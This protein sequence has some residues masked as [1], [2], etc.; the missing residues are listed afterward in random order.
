M[1]I[2]KTIEENTELENVGMFHY[3]HETDYGK[4]TDTLIVAGFMKKDKFKL[5]GFAES[6][7]A[8][9]LETVKTFSQAGECEAVVFA[10]RSGFNIGIA[11]FTQVQNFRYNL[12]GKLIDDKNMPWVKKE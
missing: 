10:I 5:K 9:A 6:E 8:G 11:N 2:S 1:S 4:R 3:W 7:T 12:E